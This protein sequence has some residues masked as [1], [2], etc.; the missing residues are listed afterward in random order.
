MRVIVT[1][2][3]QTVI[4]NDRMKEGRRKRGKRDLSSSL[5]MTSKPQGT[6]KKDTHNE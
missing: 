4:H 6:T 1:Q 5:E 3:I 2:G